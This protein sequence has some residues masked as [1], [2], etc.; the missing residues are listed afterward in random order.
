MKLEMIDE[1]PEIRHYNR[2]QDLI[3][4]FANSG[5]PA[6]KIIFRDGECKNLSCARSNIAA[7]IKRS[8][9]PIK[10]IKRKNNLYLVHII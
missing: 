8:R 2:W 3:W 10:V 4:Q 7:A 6:A 1:I 5:K 9:F